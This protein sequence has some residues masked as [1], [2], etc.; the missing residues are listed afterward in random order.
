M[1]LLL[2]ENIS[3]RLVRRLA[4]LYPDS[5]HVCTSGLGGAEDELIWE[6]AKQHG[7]YI[8]TQDSDFADRV[9]LYGAPPKVILLKCGNAPTRLVE[10]ILRE[11]A[12]VLAELEADP[13]SHIIELFA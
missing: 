3:D 6:H 11:N 4:D 2:D 1:K 5:D 10:R 7:F 13:G 12:Q 9:Q 8:V